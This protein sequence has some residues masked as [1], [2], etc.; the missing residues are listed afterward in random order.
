MQNKIQSDLQPLILEASRLKDEGAEGEV[1]AEQQEV[2]PAPVETPKSE[3]KSADLM[4]TF[5]Q[6]LEKEMGQ[7]HGLVNIYRDNAWDGLIEQITGVGNVFGI[8][9]LRAGYIDRGESTDFILMPG[10]QTTV[11]AVNPKCPKD[12]ILQVLI[13]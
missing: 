13:K 1:E 7:R 12:K 5:K 9:Q 10:Q 3:P 8:G 11:L 4:T 2:K 6:K